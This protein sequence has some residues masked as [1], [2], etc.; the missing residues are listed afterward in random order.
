MQLVPSP[1]PPPLVVIDHDADH[2]ALLSTALT[3]AG[4][5]VTVATDGLAGLLVVEAVDPAIVLVAWDLPLIPGV[6]VVHALNVGLDQPPL[7]VALVGVTD[8]ERLVVGDGVA[9]MLPRRPTAEAAL[10][11]VET[12]LHPS[13]DT[14]TS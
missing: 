14:A 12:V 13:A 10:A 3:A 6:V 5:A 11:V 7:V 8:Q 2:A 1:D 9:A 4:Y